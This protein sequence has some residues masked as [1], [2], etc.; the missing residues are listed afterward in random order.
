MDQKPKI[1]AEDILRDDDKQDKLSDEISPKQK[2]LAEAIRSVVKASGNEKLPSDEK[3]ALWERITQ[4]T[5]QQKE[6]VRLPVWLKIAASVI[7]ISIV[8][9]WYLNKDDGSNSAL[10]NFASHG[11]FSTPSDETRL[12]LSENKVFTL[13]GESSIAY[14]KSG[15]I[16]K[17]SIKT[18]DE[19]ISAGASSFNTLIVPYGRRSQLTLADGTQVWLNSGSR[20]IYPAVFSSDSRE[21]FLEGEAYFAV[22]HNREKPF[23]VHTKN[24]KVKVLGTEFN[25]SAYADDDKNFTVLV[26]GSIELAAVGQSWF[27]EERTTLRP[28]ELAELN[29]KSKELKQSKTEVE[30]YISWKNG[31][32]ILDRTPLDEIVKRLSR[33][34]NIPVK[35]N[36]K[37]SREDTFS[38]RLDLQKNLEDIMNLICAGT[39]YIY[40]P[41]ERRLEFKE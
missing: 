13:S 21:V 2:E 38:G 32:I 17:D 37:T 24:T 7:L 12:I 20:L 18:L 29:L 41:E 35:I 30:K 31:Y 9:L 40:N 36:F 4:D 1:K 26:K 16:I 25:V 33:Y 19:P 39:S 27:K 3:T 14:G 10:R 5:L 6:P 22:S 34:Y 23:Y 28:G 15:L 8:S 11:K